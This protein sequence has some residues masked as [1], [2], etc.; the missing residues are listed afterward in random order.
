RA[1]RIADYVNA[2]VDKAKAAV[3]ET[4]FFALKPPVVVRVW[5]AGD[6]WRIEAAVARRVAAAY[7][8][9]AVGNH[10]SLSSPDWAPLG[11]AV[12]LDG[13]DATCTFR[14]EDVAEPHR[15]EPQVTEVRPIED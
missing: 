11:R 4:V 8:A 2:L 5:Q 1:D 13:D 12:L 9:V 7:R 14:L 10:G 3:A 6:E 15:V